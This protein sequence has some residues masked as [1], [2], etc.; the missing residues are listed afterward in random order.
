MVLKKSLKNGFKIEDK[1]GEEKTKHDSIAL[2]AKNK[3]DDVRLA[4]EGEDEAP[5]GGWGWM[6]TF[7]MVIVFVTTIGPSNSFT[8]VFGDFLDAT[9]QA[10]SVTTMLNSLFNISYSLAGLVTSPLL[11]QFS[12]KS[13]GVVGAIIFC[14]PNVM[15]AFVH[16]VIEMAVSSFLQGLGLGLLF[17]ICNINF[18]AYFVK[19]RSMIMGIAQVIVGLGNIVYPIAIEMMMEEY[20]FRGTAL[21]IGALGLNCIPAM[22]LMRPPDIWKKNFK[23]KK[24]HKEGDNQ[25]DESKKPLMST[26][27]V[28]LAPREV[29]LLKK[30][31][32]WNSVRSLQEDASKQPDLT[33]EV[34]VASV[35]D[36]EGGV[37]RE[38]SKSLMVSGLR[39]DR[40]K[41]RKGLLAGFTSS[42][43]T[44]LRVQPGPETLTNVVMQMQGT[45]T[46]IAE[47]D[48]DNDG[49]EMD[50]INEKTSN[51]FGARSRRIL[52]SLIDFSLLKNP[53]FLNMCL[54]LSFV[55]TSDLTFSTFLPLMMASRDF[56][57]ADAALAITAS[58]TAELVSRIAYA[59]FAI[60]YDVRPKVIFFVAMC[61]MSLVR[62][63]YLYLEDTLSGTIIM[64]AAI[65]AVRSWLF[66]SQSLV[67][68]EDIRVDQFAAAYGVYA[69]VSGVI[70]ITIGPL[71][72]L[73]K[74]WT[75]S[76]T[77]CQIVL[78]IMNTVFIVPWAVEI[79]YSKKKT[80][81]EAQV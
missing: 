54:G 70:S 52:D 61:L 6:V 55:F 4:E 12:M 36:V 28:P 38:R 81:S 73:V 42:S 51:F 35:S 31:S 34:R 5:D 7:G 69:I 24:Q 66:V 10:G 27:P 8:I 37:C 75:D 79:I 29:E 45:E 23:S 58:A 77:V 13:V 11:K 41:V 9:H 19:K 48:R 56:T 14:I 16:Q 74:D 43:L 39:Y 80:R 30:A 15:L 62:I 65:G 53:S 17:T 2:P 50:V 63:G 22:A 40:P 71:T 57:K 76:F 67:I 60:F 49:V 26:D 47:D 1:Q 46:A 72:G 18:N 25:V 59:T 3:E 32:K 78:V 68:V 33:P 20:G 21:I 44:N 64:V